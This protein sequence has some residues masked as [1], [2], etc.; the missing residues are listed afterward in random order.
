MNTSKD[1]LINLSPSKEFFI[2]IDSDGCVFDTMELKHKECFCP[3]LIDHYNLQSI[4]KYA[5]ETWEFV[6][7]YSMTRGINRF[8]GLIFTLDMLGKR[9]D[10][11]AEKLKIPKINS[12]KDWIVSEHKT[13]NA[14]LKKAVNKTN[15]SDLSLLYNWSCDVNKIICKIVRNVPPFPYVKE[16]LIK[17]RKY[18][19]SIVISSA[20][21]ESLN[22]EWSENEME[23]YVQ[24][25][26]GQEFGS[27]KDCF[28]QAVKGKYSPEKTLMIGDAP[29]DM[30]AAKA[31]NA[32]FF[33]IIPEEEEKSWEL[34][35]KEGLDRFFD[36]S[37]SGEYELRLKEEF[38]AH[39]P[40][41]PTWNTN[42]KR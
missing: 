7:L 17:I 16:S 10:I 22:S 24:I 42:L 20:N 13:G 21:Q 19:D 2:G 23:Q 25:I 11:D 3:A 27:K 4:S 26:A 29:G 6:N 41:H 35:Y 1:A 39:L 30:A 8:E 37:Y 28:G 14:S 5:R 9:E 15:D 36:G 32:L 18:A 31:N 38:L 40:E 33:P 12:V 34:F